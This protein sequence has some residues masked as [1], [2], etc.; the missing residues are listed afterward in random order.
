MTVRR[1]LEAEL[2]L[3]ARAALGEGPDWDEEC[4]REGGAVRFA[5]DGRLDAVVEPPVGLVMS[6]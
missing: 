6:W 2:V 1:R 3:D 4:Q 5:P